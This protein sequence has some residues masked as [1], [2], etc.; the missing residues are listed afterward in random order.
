MR[1]HRSWA[2]LPLVLL[3][4][5]VPPRTPPVELRSPFRPIKLAELRTG[6]EGFVHQKV[7]FSAT[8]DRV[9]ETPGGTWLYLRDGEDRVVLYTAMS[10]GGSFRD[11]LG[12]ERMQFEVEIG[13]KKLTPLGTYA[14]EVLPYQISKTTYFE[15][16]V[17]LDPPPGP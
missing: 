4:A 14:L 10:F 16:A 12:K 15:Q 17:P 13:E 2:L 1:T 8:I 11:S 3:V 6:S 9:E 5:C 7:A